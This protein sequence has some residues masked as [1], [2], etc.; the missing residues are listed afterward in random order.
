MSHEI[1][2]DK[3]INTSCSD[4]VYHAH[5]NT[6][7]SSS[8]QSA[9]SDF[10][11]LPELVSRL[12]NYLSLSDFASL[13]LVCW[14]IHHR[15]NPILYERISLD[16]SQYKDTKALSTLEALLAESPA[17]ANAVRCLYIRFQDLRFTE[18]KNRT[19]HSSLSGTITKCPHLREL[20]I[21]DHLPRPDPISSHVRRPYHGERSINEM[22][23]LSALRSPSLENIS[24]TL[25]ESP[26]TP[27][28]TAT[29]P[30]SETI[31]RLRLDD[32]YIEIETLRNIITAVPRLRHLDL[33]L[34]RYVDPGLEM[35]DVDSHLDIREFWAAV[36]PVFAT[37]ESLQLEIAYDVRTAI[38]MSSTL[39]GGE[40]SQ[41][42]PFGL[43][44]SL[45]SCHKLKF[46]EIAPEALLG[47]E[48]DETV[49]LS[50]VL[51]GTLETL[52]F[53]PDFDWWEN[54]PWDFLPLSEKVGEYLKSLRHASLKH[55]SIPCDGHEA[56][57]RKD[58]VNSF[59][60][61]CNGFGVQIFL[62]IRSTGPN[63]NLP[64]RPPWAA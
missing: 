35:A 41:H 6:T 43:M 45:Q 32:A 21:L 3:T 57:R 25:H 15:A 47:W 40:G 48:G 58:A 5:S 20:S 46:L 31:T 4:K 29:L 54:S 39:G 61:L 37:L 22:A 27:L 55:L 12:R 13:C 9:F 56:K 24:L 7:M 8:Q 52:S 16:I 59:A 19:H 51:P 50:S 36:K 26:Q 53:R 14:N 60:Q 64:A 23:L 34:V 42:G 1:V 11:L 49:A 30:I 38:D 2:K 62:Q 28:R 18:S 10:W 44:P 33:C 17:L 63:A